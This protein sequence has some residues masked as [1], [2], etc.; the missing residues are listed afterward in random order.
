MYRVG[1]IDTCLYLTPDKYVAYYDSLLTKNLDR[2]SIKKSKVVLEVDYSFGRDTIFR[3]RLI[4][5]TEKKFNSKGRVL[6]EYHRD[7]TIELK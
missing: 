7:L 4:D 3:K 2:I 6:N 1:T 5:I